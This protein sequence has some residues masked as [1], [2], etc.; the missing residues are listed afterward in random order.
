MKIKADRRLFW[1]M[2]EDIVFDISDTK[3]IDMYVQQVLTHGATKD[4]K[5]LIKLIGLDTLKKSLTRVKN[6]L[7]AEVRSFWESSIGNR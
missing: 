4:I 6:F 2:K 3:S 1:F 7:P 5:K